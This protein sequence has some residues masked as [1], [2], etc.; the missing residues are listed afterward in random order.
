MNQTKDTI[1]ANAAAPHHVINA[2]EKP[3]GGKGAARELRRQG[4]TPAVIYGAKEATR[5]LGLNTK[6]LTRALQ[7]G[8][9]FTHAQ[10]I[11]LGENTFKV[12]PRDIQRHPV[13]DRPIHVDFMTYDAAR[14]VHVNVAVRIVG[15]AESPGIKAGGVLQLIEAE[16]EVICR[17][18]SIPQQIEISVAGLEIGDAVHLS[19]VKLPA[20]VKPGVTDRDL[21]IASVISTRTAATAADEAADAAAAAEAAAEGAAPGAEGAAAPA[22]DA[23]KAA[24][25]DSD[26]KTDKR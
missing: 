19:E 26:A 6:D 21:T 16:I 2:V 20:G 9:F 5:M 10:E 22:A 15:E 4:F 12:L 14:Q 25:K 1:M 17:A 13:T 8:H 18:D 24:K 7:L 23:A 3:K 11:K